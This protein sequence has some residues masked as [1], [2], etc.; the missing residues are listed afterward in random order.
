MD[1][2]GQ[3]AAQFGETD[4]QHAEAAFGVHAEV[5]EQ[6]EIL[7]HVVAKVLGLVDDQDGQLRGL[8]DEAGD[9]VADG[10]VG[11]GAGA[12]LGQAQFPCYGL[13]YVEHVA[14]GQRDVVDAVQTGMEP[15]GDAPADGG[16]AGPHLAGEQ[17]DAAQLD[18]VLQ[19]RLGLAVCAGL[20]QLV[21]GEVVLERQPGGL[22]RRRPSGR[23]AWCGS[24][25]ST[26]V[27]SACRAA[28]C[29]RRCRVVRGNSRRPDGAGSAPGLRDA[30]LGP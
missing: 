18:E 20:E 15:G 8:L 6:A 13:V 7:E 4:Q 12:L 26:S 10:A 28:S 29:G 23:A 1:G 16:L 25:D 3:P 21:V 2:H 9:L 24:R 14:G 11:G 27:R 30:S 17:S 19:A 5:G 22:R